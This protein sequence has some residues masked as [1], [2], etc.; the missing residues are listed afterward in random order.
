MASAS[1]AGTLGQFL[2]R[3]VR[4]R[5]GGGGRVLGRLRGQPEQRRDD[6]LSDSGRRRM[7]ALAASPSAPS[8]QF[9]VHLN[10][11]PPAVGGPGRVGSGRSTAHLH[12]PPAASGLG[13]VGDGRINR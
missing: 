12:I 5:R 4:W 3:G 8:V 2:W 9:R 10:L 7:R 11:L 13:Q 6:V 1:I